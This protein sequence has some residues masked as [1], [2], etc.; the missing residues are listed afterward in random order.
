MA[1]LTER[2]LQSLKPRGSVY[3]VADGLGLCV[4]VHPS[5]AMYWR[6]RYR[7]AGKAR[8]LSLGTF[9][10]TSGQA[11][12]MGLALARRALAD[13]RLQLAE[14][15]DPVS[16]RRIAR[17]TQREDAA[18]T[19]E[20]F[21]REWLARLDLAPATMS[22]KRWLLEDLAFPWIG[23]R[24]IAEVSPP[25]LL[26]LLRRVEGRGKL[27]TAQR[28]RQ[29]LGEVFRYGVAC[30]YCE[31]D[32]TRDLRGA[33]ATPKVRH[34]ASLTEPAQVS[35]LMRAIHGHQGTMQVSAALRMLPLVFVRPGELRTAEWAE[36]DLAAAVWR[37]PAEKTKMR[38]PHLVPLPA[39]AVTILQDLQPLTGAG[40]Y[41]FPS[42][43][44]R[45]RPMSENTINAAL[46]GLG[47]SK[48]QMTA[49][50]FRAMARTMLA[51]QGWLPEVIERQLAHKA[52]GPLGAAYDRAQYLTERRRMLQAW[53]DYLDSLRAGRG[54]VVGLRQS[55]A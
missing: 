44:S 7:H 26:S 9:R 43:R 24:P 45:L 5:G 29:T 15:I 42:T 37:I 31:S 11:G 35:E 41:V 54:K 18:N 10:T 53:A 4:E 36:F 19:F 1:T 12:P 32:P 55:A 25:E 34:R 46:R 47:F 8:M 22:K 48:D 39:Q 30:G 49:H 13:A 33:I 51:E 14:G 23:S 38:T 2:K 17:A 20:S 28:L 6:F 16:D 3:R 50:G 52:S 40:R 21:A 27:E